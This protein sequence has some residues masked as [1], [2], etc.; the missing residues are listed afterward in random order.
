MIAHWA[1]DPS[2]SDEAKPAACTLWRTKREIKPATSVPTKRMAAAA[3]TL[4]MYSK[5]S[6]KKD[7]ICDNPRISAAA[8]KI[9]RSKNHLTTQA[10]V[11]ATVIFMPVRLESWSRP[12][13]S[14]NSS[15]LAECKTDLISLATA[16]ATI[17]PTTKT[18]TA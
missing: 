12:S 3:T 13:L 4:G 2:M 7:E 6:F 17:Q 14:P 15:T 10:I 11:P 1:T 5:T 9:A 18:M 8:R 16:A